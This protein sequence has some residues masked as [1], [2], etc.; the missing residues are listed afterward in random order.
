MKD[1]YIVTAICLTVLGVAAIW[2][3]GCVE[4]QKAE[5][6]VQQIVRTKYLKCDSGI[7]DSRCQVIYECNGDCLMGWIR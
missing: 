3:N 5:H 1:F 2:A 6:P 7:V 4:V